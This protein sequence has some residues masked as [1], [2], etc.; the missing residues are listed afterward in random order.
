MQRVLAGILVS[1]F[2]LTSTPLAA[3]GEPAAEAAAPAV[4]PEAPAAPVAAEAPAP[5]AVAAAPEP[6]PGAVEKPEKQE[7]CVIRAVMTDAEI[8]TCRRVAATR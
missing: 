5:A 6:V 7:V 4:Q 8:E 3:Q 1:L 2:A